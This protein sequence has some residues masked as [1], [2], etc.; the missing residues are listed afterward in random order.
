MAASSRHRDPHL[1]SPPRSLDTSQHPGVGGDDGLHGGGGVR[2]RPVPWDEE[3][4]PA[5]QPRRDRR[6]G[7]VPAA[8]PYIARGGGG[9]GGGGGRGGAGPGRM[10]LGP[11]RG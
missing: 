2:S 8:H 7:A 11:C 9:G 6:V 1:P 3:E 10:P 4:Q 5:P